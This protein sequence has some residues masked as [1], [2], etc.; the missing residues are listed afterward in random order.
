MFNKESEMFLA[1]FE[2]YFITEEGK[3][4]HI[5][6]ISGYKYYLTEPTL[7]DILKAFFIIEQYDA[8]RVVFE[9]YQPA[10]NEIRCFELSVQALKASEN[11]KMWSQLTEKDATQPK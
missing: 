3:T 9:I 8:D 2:N 4:I 6:T 5:S 11:Y 7:D 10:F 1:R